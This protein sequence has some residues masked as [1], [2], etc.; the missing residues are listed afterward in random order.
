MSPIGLG[1]FGAGLQSFALHGSGFGPFPS[2]FRCPLSVPVSGSITSRSVSLTSARPRVAV[3]MNMYRLPG[4][5]LHLGFHLPWE[6]AVGAGWVFGMAAF[7]DIFAAILL[8]A[9]LA[10][11]GHL[12]RRLSPRGS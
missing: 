10:W 5:L 3:A 12:L 1:I 8:I 4:F 7:F 2:G 6:A 9:L 11:K